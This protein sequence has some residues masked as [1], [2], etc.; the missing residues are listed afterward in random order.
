MTTGALPIGKCTNIAVVGGKLKATIE[1]PPPGCYPFADQVRGLVDA[2]FLTAA[3]VGFRADRSEPNGFGGHDIKR[4]TL[5]EWSV[6][7]IPSNPSAL[8]ERGRGQ[9]A[10]QRL[11]RAT[12]GANH[13]RRTTCR[14][15][16]CGSK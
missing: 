14:P 2:G 6:V 13:T 8:M 5:L 3:S 15:R 1:W 16:N 4:A 9:D 12:D 10:A 11:V 7:N